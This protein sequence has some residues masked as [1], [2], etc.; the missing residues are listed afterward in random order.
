MITVIEG[1]GGSGKSLVLA[2][3]TKAEVD[4]GQTV[5]TQGP[6][7]FNG[8]KPFDREVFLG[9]CD[10]REELHDCSFCLDEVYSYFDSRQ[11]GSRMNRLFTYIT[12][13]SRRR[14]VNFYL[15]THHIDI[16]DKRIQ[17][18]V[19]YRIQCKGVGG[20]KIA[21]HLFDTY[22]KWNLRKRIEIAKWLP[23]VTT[24]DYQDEVQSVEKDLALMKSTL[25]FK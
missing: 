24:T 7:S 8:W 20:G 13:Q 10:S 17:R 25:G 4:R 21:L 5:Y 1:V 3:L 12:V 11:A 9:L 2:A 19:D 22:G 16:I 6:F 15:T 14:N 23:L 18:A